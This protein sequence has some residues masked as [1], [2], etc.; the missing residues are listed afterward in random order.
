MKDNGWIGLTCDYSSS[1]SEKQSQAERQVSPL[2]N[3]GFS[4][5]LMFRMECQARAVSRKLAHHFEYPERDNWQDELILIAEL[6]RID[7]EEAM[8]KKVCIRK[9]GADISIPWDKNFCHSLKKALFLDWK[10][11]VAMLYLPL[12]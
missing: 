9:H 10:Q 12:V 5:S 3:S 8:K 7:L 2:T 6:E 11:R 4:G 1:F